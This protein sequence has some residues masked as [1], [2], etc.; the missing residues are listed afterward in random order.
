MNLLEKYLTKLKQ[1]EKQ[2]VSIQTSYKQMSGKERKVLDSW[3]CSDQPVPWGDCVNFT[4][5][6]HDKGCLVPFCLKIDSWCLTSSTC[7]H[8]M[9]SG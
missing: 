1:S 9:E 2:D 5:R 3:Q 6:L 7:T 8:A 4:M